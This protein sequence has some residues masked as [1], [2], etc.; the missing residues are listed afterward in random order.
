MKDGSNAMI[1]KKFLLLLALAAPL[2]LRA[3]TTTRP[4]R[5]Y[6]QQ[7]VDYHFV[8][9]YDF[10]R[11]DN[12]DHFIDTSIFNGWYYGTNYDDLD[13]SKI[14][15]LISD[16]VRVFDLLIDDRIDTLILLVD[17]TGKERL[18]RCLTREENPDVD[19]IVR[20]YSDEIDEY[21]GRDFKLINRYIKPVVEIPNHDGGFEDAVKL[22]LDAIENW[23]K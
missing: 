18:L 3:Q 15:V 4:M 14:N 13:P 6:E 22:A 2:C 11:E 20:R 8:D 23:A 16:N 17:A 12:L 7:D 19:E 21:D 5:E 10:L 1:M 9:R